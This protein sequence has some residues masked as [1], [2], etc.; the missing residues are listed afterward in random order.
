MYKAKHRTSEV[1]YNASAEQY[2]SQS[3]SYER[4]LKLLSPFIKPIDNCSHK[5]TGKLITCKTLKQWI[6][7]KK[8]ENIIRDFGPTK[9]CTYTLL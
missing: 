9:V 4:V 2:C 8:G 5:H 7:G 6:P 1:L 3:C